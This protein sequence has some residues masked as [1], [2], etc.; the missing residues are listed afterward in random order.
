M[1]VY[2]ITIILFGL[3]VFLIADFG[4]G[5]KRAAAARK[6]L[7]GKEPRAFDSVF[8]RLFLP[9]IERLAPGLDKFRY[10]R[11]RKHI[12]EGLIRA[13]LGDKLKVEEFWAYQV[14][15]PVVFI[16]VSMILP[17][18]ISFFSLL[19]A[20]L[21]GFFYPLIWLRSLKAKRRKEISYGL[22]LVLDLLT[23]SVEAGLDFISATN[24]I[25]EKSEGSLMAAELGRML[26]QIKLG[27]SRAEAL[28]EF[29]QRLA[30]PSIDS[31]VAMLI[32]AQR[33]G[34]SIGPIL[35]AH[36]L[37]LRSDRFQQAEKAGVVA[38]QKLLVPLIF[39][40]MPAVFI[41]VFGPILVMW[42]TG[43]FERMF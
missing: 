34:A 28:L 7:L 39:C 15:M 35:K 26:S 36:A 29:K 3:S 11:Y 19:L 13:G 18:K 30:H 17:T 20:V 25:V 5:W 21:A 31:F 27:K 33:L 41:V 23:L 38:A 32:Q 14:L 43:V 9:V 22:P 10:D 12:A 2:I 8:L 1:A 42:K 4:C 24:R 40:I 6:S 37:K 16:A